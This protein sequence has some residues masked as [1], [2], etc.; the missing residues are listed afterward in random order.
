MLSF[1]PGFVKELNKGERKENQQKNYPGE[2]NNQG[3]KQAKIGMEGD[4]AKAKGGHNGKRPVKTGDPTELPALILHEDVEKKAVKADDSGKKNKK[5]EQDNK[6]SFCTLILQE[7]DD[8]WKRL[9][10][11]PVKKTR[12]IVFSHAGQVAC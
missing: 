4:I 8:N 7:I 5:F 9:H 2:K 10:I 3:E 11:Q 1:K 6:I 12:K